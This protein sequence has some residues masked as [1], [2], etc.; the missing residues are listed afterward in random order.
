MPFPSG[1][2][3]DAAQREQNQ[4]EKVGVGP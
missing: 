1:A 4:S 3:S 2:T